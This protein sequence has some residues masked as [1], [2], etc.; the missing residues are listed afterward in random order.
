[1]IDD[2]RID[3]DFWDHT[4]TIRLIRRLGI[5]AA[6]C[7]QKLWC[8]AAKQRPDG[9][10]KGMSSDDIELAAK[11]PGARGAF[12]EAIKRDW[13]E[14]DKSKRSWMLHDWNVRNPWVANS[15]ERKAASR[16][17]AHITNHA[18]RKRFVSTCEYCRS[19]R[20]TPENAEAVSPRHHRRSTGGDTERSTERYTERSILHA[21][22]PIAHR[23]REAADAWNAMQA[24]EALGD[25][26]RRIDEP[27]IEQLTE[28]AEKVTAQ[29]LAVRPE[30]TW[31]EC[32]SRI[33]RKSWLVRE[34]KAFSFE[35]LFKHDQHGTEF[36][37]VKVWD[38]RL[39]EK[40]TA[41]DEEPLFAF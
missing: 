22:A 24:V 30:F 28:I 21:P 41:A 35:W 38:G 11:W 4:K 7:L 13:L 40:E 9:V 23:A 26:A 5:E 27:T 8:Y 1:M 29:I 39:G 19:E 32:I 20:A 17:G 2:I 18:K 14:R 36:N 15:P 12:F 31:L 6:V 33:D 25:R 34:S 37:A 10:L 16:K 3:V